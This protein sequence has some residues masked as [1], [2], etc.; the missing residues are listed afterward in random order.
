MYTLTVLGTID[1]QE[2]FDA[3]LLYQFFLARFPKGVFDCDIF[4]LDH[5]SD[6]PPSN[7]CP[8]SSKC[9]RWKEVSKLLNN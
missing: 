7:F 9:N 6:V 3:S 5:P 4:Q 2:K 1:I 8:V